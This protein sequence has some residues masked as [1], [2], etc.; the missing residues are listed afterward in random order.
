MI[1]RSM[2]DEDVEA[3]EDLSSLA[4]AALPALPGEEVS[5]HPR[6]PD[7]VR[8]WQRRAR[9][10]L[11]TDPGGCWAAYDDDGVLLGVATSLR[12]EGLWGLSTLTVRPGHQDQGIGRTLMERA[13]AYGEGALRGMICSSHDPRAVRL[14]RAFG[15][16]LHPAMGFRGRA[17]RA[18]SPPVRQVREGGVDDLDFADAV[19]RL[20]RGA[21]HGPDHRML[22]EDNLLLVAETSTGRGY[23]YLRD[24][25]EPVLLAATDER[26]ATELLWAALLR[27]P[28]G[29]EVIVND[30][31]S[32]QSWAVDVAVA[33]G[34]SITLAGF[35]CVRGM[36]PPMPYIPSGAYL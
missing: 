34:L 28:E 5:T 25:N 11:G 1:I 14:Y 31:T 26:T 20:V 36:R 12:R 19:D 32:E 18:V 33:A 22:A 4:F 23:C 9:H 7:G 35:V 21:P 3:A 27:M 10:L 6:S 17:D 15:H 13:S 29:T 8:R 16:R 30:V 24:Q 2:R